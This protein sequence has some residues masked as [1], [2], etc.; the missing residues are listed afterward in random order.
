MVMD[1]CTVNNGG[2]YSS[3]V[4]T[5]WYDGN[6]NTSGKPATLVIEDAQITGGIVNVKVDDY[7]VLRI[8]GGKLSGADENAVLNWN[9]CEVSGGELV[10]GGV[11]CISTGFLHEAMDK[12]VLRVTGGDFSG[13]GI[14]VRISS[15]ASQPG[16]PQVSGGTFSKAVDPQFIAEGC[17]QVEQDGRF[18]VRSAN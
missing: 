6:K 15:N 18:V 7:G 14:M 16:D 3:A 11:A 10:S 13:D 2:S 8:K 17:E 9:E 5:G 4:A 1:G 12:G